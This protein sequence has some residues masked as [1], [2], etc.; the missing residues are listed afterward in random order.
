MF[1]LAVQGVHGEQPA[2]EPQFLDHL[3][4]GGDFVAFVV[5]QQMAQDQSL[6]DRESAQDMSRLLVGKGIETVPE[7][8]AV[9]GH[10]RQRIH[11]L[12]GFLAAQHHGMLAEN[13][14]H[15]FRV[16]LL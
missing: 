7:R 15:L 2:L 12:A 8:L 11:V 13:P 4:R 5:H 14:L 16:E 10:D 1:F 9:D 6:I 3:L